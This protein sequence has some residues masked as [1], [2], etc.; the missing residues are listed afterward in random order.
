MQKNNKGFTL[1]ETM[2][3][4]FIL[5]ISIVSLMNVVASSLFAAKYAR[6]EIT[7]NYLLQEVIDYIRNDRD[8]VFLKSDNP[9][10]GWADFVEKYKLCSEDQECYIEVSML[11]G[12]Q[13]CAED[14]CPLYYNNNSG[15]N[16]PIYTNDS[17]ATGVVKSKFS[18]QII[19]EDIGGEEMRVRVK[20]K[21]KNGSLDK[22][23]TLETSLLKWQ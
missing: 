18:R 17:G 23:R 22:Y 6:D 9:E 2:V 13:P 11:N 19:I 7:A 14:N 3:A 10:Q 4:V 20:V 5:A 8:T 12:P 15:A 1:I 21:W 16:K